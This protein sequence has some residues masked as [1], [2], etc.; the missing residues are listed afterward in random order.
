MDNFSNPSDVVA[1]LP[2]FAG[3]KVA[4]F[5]AGSGAYSFALAHR[6]SGAESG[7]VYAVDL[8]QDML[9]R[10]ESHAQ[11]DGINSIMTVWGDI[12]HAQGSRLR[13]DSID[14]VVIANVLFQTDDKQAV[15]REAYRVL[16][17]GGVV[18]I[19][20][21]SESFGNLGPTE[22]HVV[23]EHTARVI[24]EENGFQFVKTIEAGAHHYGFLVRK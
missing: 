3:Q 20:D 14:A 8:H 10:I 13:E 4:D 2:V 7:V 12:E 6:V 24:A 17:P 18:G 19:I 22:N 16:K 11:E 9:E 1:Q 23:S 21:W 15:F 5:G